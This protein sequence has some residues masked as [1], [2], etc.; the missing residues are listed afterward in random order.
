MRVK[1]VKIGIKRVKDV[2]EDVKET[3]KKL[4]RGG[5]AKDC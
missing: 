4:E 1:K 5:K 2:L 3:V